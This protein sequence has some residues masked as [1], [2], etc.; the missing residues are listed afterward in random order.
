MRATRTGSNAV[1]GRVERI[2]PTR[3][4]AANIPHPSSDIR[5]PTPSPTH[6][7]PHSTLHTRTK[8]NRSTP[9]SSSKFKFKKV[10]CAD[11]PPLSLSRCD[12]DVMFT[13]IVR[14]SR[15]SEY[16]S[17][18]TNIRHPTPAHSQTPTRTTYEDKTQPQHS[19]LRFK[20]KRKVQ[21]ADSPPLS[22]YRYD[23]KVQIHIKFKCA[24]RILTRYAEHG[25]QRRP[26]QAYLSDAQQQ[27]QCRGAA[28]IPHPTPTL[29]ST[30]KTQTQ[31]PTHSTRKQNSNA[32]PT[33]PVQN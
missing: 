3:S 22:L 12:S 6:S 16:P 33:T 14:V 19:P 8:L 28:N 2:C 21:R 25:L 30:R 11:S 9:H 31:T 17:S 7:P 20:I 10:R 27:Q 4:R 26:R 24:L 1:C 29:I 18:D 32:A 23:S 13:P 15:S 5:H